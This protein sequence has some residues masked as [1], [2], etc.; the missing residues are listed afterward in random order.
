MAESPSELEMQFEAIAAYSTRAMH[1]AD[2]Y[3]SIVLATFRA[4]EVLLERIRQELDRG[5]WTEEQRGHLD[6]H[7]RQVEAFFLTY[8]GWSFREGVSGSAAE[9][10]R[11]ATANPWRERLPNLPAQPPESPASSK[12]WDGINRIVGHLDSL[13]TSVFNVK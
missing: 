3:A 11:H 12:F 2:R 9:T 10:M 6:E 4:Y 7:T 8:A 13:V 1:A 5:D